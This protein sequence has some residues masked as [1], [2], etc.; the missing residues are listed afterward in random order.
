MWEL[1]LH[2]AMYRLG[3]YV[4]YVGVRPVVHKGQL[5]QHASGLPRRFC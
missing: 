4:Q 1:L 3:Y 5:G 2:V